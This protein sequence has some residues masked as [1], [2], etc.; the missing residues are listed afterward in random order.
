[1]HFYL[2]AHYYRTCWRR[3]HPRLTYSWHVHRIKHKLVFYFYFA[4][5]D[6]R[7]LIIYDPTVN[8]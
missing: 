5:A 7:Y 8:A 4:L 2:P 3:R 6:E 1:M